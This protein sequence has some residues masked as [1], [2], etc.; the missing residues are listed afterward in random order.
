MTDYPVVN[1]ICAFIVGVPMFYIAWWFLYRCGKD[2]N[3]E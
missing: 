1:I 2:N 3:D